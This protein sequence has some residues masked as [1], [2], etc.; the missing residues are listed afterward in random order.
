MGLI[1]TQSVG[2]G[3]PQ[4]K[5]PNQPDPKPVLGV[6]YAGRPMKAGDFYNGRP[7]HMAPPDKMAQ[8]R[9]AITPK[10]ERSPGQL[11]KMRA[12]IARARQKRWENRQKA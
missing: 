10:E 2:F 3:N 11:A 8:M 1:T 12:S 6:D 5:D 9:A 4:R 7:E